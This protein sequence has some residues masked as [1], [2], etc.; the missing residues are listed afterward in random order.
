MCPR[1]AACASSHYYV[2]VLA[3]TLLFAA[4][5]GTDCALNTKSPEQGAEAGGG[6]GRGGGGLSG[7]MGLKRDLVRVLG[8][9][10][11]EDPPSQNAVREEGAMPL[12]LRVCV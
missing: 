7:Q 1:T 6:G 11:Y 10:C 2:C 3:L 12:I 5:P 9:M 4:V 8:N